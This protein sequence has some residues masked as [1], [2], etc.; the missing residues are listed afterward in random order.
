MD[1]PSDASPDRC[2]NRNFGPP[3]QHSRG[4]HKIFHVNLDHNKET[5]EGE[6]HRLRA[7]L[8]GT[9]ARASAKY[10]IA[11]TLPLTPA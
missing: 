1:A 8:L 2:S 7:A 6:M 3:R 5:A 11:A 4:R 10:L 9:C